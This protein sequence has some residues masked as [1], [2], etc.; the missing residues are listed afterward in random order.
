MNELASR[1]QELGQLPFHPPSVKGWDGGR[2]WINAATILSRANLVEQMVR[3][4][5]T[6]FA[7]GDLAA[8]YRNSKYRGAS[9]IATHW[10]AVDLPPEIDRELARTIPAGQTAT[11]E[12]VADAMTQLAVLPEFQLN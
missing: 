1:M 7:D 8:W 11:T 12:Q 5:Q 2:T 3:S 9:D 4:G 6:K 10:L